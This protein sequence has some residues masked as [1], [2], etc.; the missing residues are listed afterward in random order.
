MRTPGLAALLLGA[1]TLASPPAAAD[2]GPCAALGGVAQAGTC[3]VSAG[4]PAYTI[5]ISFPL[6]FPGEQAI[7]DYLAQTREGFVNVAQ[8]PGF[9]ARPHEMD[10]TAQSFQSAQTRSVVLRLFQDIG[11][12]HPA[13]W[14]KAFTHD[15]AQGRPVTFEALFDPG[16]HPLDAIFPIVQRTLESETALAAGISPADGRDPANYQNFAVTDDSVI[17]FFGRA[18]LLPS[19]AGATSVAVP[20]DAI[21]P[22]RL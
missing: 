18:E 16:S 1:V 6:G 19:Y 14:Y 8:T 10:V 15:L 13:T 7:V 9:R 17:F 11:T 12:A 3:R 22:L 21:P 5:D 20:R 2:P 4:N